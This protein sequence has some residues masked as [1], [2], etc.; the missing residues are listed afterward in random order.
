MDAVHHAAGVEAENDFSLEVVSPTEDAIEITVSGELDM[1]NADSFSH[2][3]KQAIDGQASAIVVDLS[4]LSFMDSAGL[5]PLVA[6]A[7][8][9]HDL[10]VRKP[11]GEPARLLQLT[12]M[13]RLLNF[14]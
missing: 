13:D 1:A 10:R 3:L 9:S 8:G 7:R 11:Q 4:R 14:L 5:R 2:A 12:E 6:A